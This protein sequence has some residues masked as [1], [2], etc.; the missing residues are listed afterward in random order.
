MK[1]TF[2]IFL[3]FILFVQQSI[4]Q[5]QSIN[6]GNRIVDSLK[7]V[8]KNAKHDTIKCN[9]LNAMID[10]DESQ[11]NCL[12]YSEELKKIT[13]ENLRRG[14]TNKILKQ[15]YLLN[16][17]IALNNIGYN[18]S[19]EHNPNKA[20][21]YYFKCLKI[22]KDVG[23]LDGNYTQALSNIGVA[24][25]DQG[26]IT[27]SLEYI[28]KSLKIREQLG[29]KLGIAQCLSNMGTI[30]RIQG[31]LVK[32][33][34]YL[35][36][37][38]KLFEE[39]GDQKDVAAVLC[40]LG[41]N[42]RMEGNTDKA[43]EYYNK[44]LII[45]E[46]M[47]NKS[48]GAFALNSISIV[49]RN[50]GDL[51][52]AL[53]FSSRSL[54]INEEIKDKI[55][56]VDVLTNMGQIYLKL[57]QIDKALQHA[58]RAMDILKEIGDPNRTSITAKYLTEIYKAKGDY[59][60][61]YESYLLSIALH[62]SINNQETK[63][64]SIKSQF[65]YAYEKKAAQDSVANAKESEIKNAELDK[66]KVE[67]KAKRNQQYALF[68][69]LALVIVFA[70][71]IYNRFKITQKQ[72]IIIE[73]KEKETQ[74]QNEIIT[75]QKLLVEEKQKEIL[76]SIYYAKRIQSALLPNEKYIKRKMNQLN[77]KG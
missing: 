41:I 15:F 34:E 38:L 6:A 45:C 28:D 43:I 9:I 32:T 73:L 56:L 39:L 58:N 50:L 20:L 40:N 17:A 8:F 3:L 64:A 25:Y 26:N 68:G 7:I 55:G 57:G 13:E 77:K 24:Y 48:S 67:I 42:Y 52:K 49:Y 11:E 30:F 21:E 63:K 59:K 70:A 22:Y 47:G 2:K 16:L 36:R 74:K 23:R 46:K 76:D 54:K 33:E 1:I 65:K 66:Q 14:Q 51:N 53:E 31:D 19:L 60:R 4:S 62:D 18:A 61:A 12:K 71:F 27:A 5:A 37:S 35:R 10:A 75:K 69:G 44:A 29:D 72:K